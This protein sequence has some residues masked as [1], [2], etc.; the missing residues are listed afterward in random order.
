MTSYTRI[1][2]LIGVPIV[3]FI[4]V[5]ASDLVW[6]LTGKYGYAKHANI[7]WII[8]VGS[9][10]M[11]LASISATGLVIAKNTRPMIRASV[12]AV[13]VNIGLNFALI[14]PFGL[15]GAAIATP[16]AIAV[17]VAFTYRAGRAHAR[18]AF[19]LATLVRTLTAAT[20]G[21]IAATAATP[22]G[23]WRPLALLISATVGVLVYIVVLLALGERRSLALSRA[24][25]ESEYA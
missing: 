3:A 6:I 11:A 13:V 8:A 1:A 17:Y 4:Y 14:P 7:A 20:L 9:L 22:A 23:G 19:P 2:L 12:I 21:G 15:I 25:D 10:L 18:W 24:P 16:V 5:S